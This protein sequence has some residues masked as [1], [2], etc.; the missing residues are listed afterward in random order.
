MV[1]WTGFALTLS[2]KVPADLAAAAVA[3]VTISS[4]VAIPPVFS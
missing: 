3:A 2:K 4:S 1:P